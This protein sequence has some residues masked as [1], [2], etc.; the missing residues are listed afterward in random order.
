MSRLKCSGLKIWPEG[1]WKFALGIKSDEKAKEK[2]RTVSEND[3]DGTPRMIMHQIR[4]GVVEFI[5][6]LRATKLELPIASSIAATDF[7]TA[8]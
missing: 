1:L 5:A 3:I 2:S 8:A 4:S 6:L 7:P